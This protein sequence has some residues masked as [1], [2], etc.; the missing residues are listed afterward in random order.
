[1]AA[2]CI[3]LKD[4]TAWLYPQPCSFSDLTALAAGVLD[5][6]VQKHGS[7]SPRNHMTPFEEGDHILTSLPASTL[8]RLTTISSL[9]SDAVCKL[10]RLRSLLYLTPRTPPSPNHAGV[11]GEPLSAGCGG[12][13]HPH[14]L[15]FLPCATSN[16]QDT[17]HQ[18]WPTATLNTTE[19]L[20]RD[21]ASPEKSSLTSTQPRHQSFSSRKLSTQHGVGKAPP[22]WT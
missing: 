8:D 17:L 22:L 19:P 20:W 13:S 4:R 14:S 6:A 18:F 12:S 9:Q 3:F 1:M 11:Q 16:S 5:E 2:Y 15:S 7:M 21:S 10:T